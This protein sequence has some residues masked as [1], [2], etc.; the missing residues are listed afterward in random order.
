MAL[1]ASVVFATLWSQFYYWETP[2]A[3]GQ[4]EAPSYGAWLGSG[5]QW[6]Q[7]FLQKCRTTTARMKD[8]FDGELSKNAKTGAFVEASLK[9]TI[10]PR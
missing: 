9:C 4:S 7:P 8:P 1:L 5:S 10:L 2:H 3:P 6:L